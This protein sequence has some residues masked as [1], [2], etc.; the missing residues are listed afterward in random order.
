M[1]NFLSAEKLE[2]LREAFD[3]GMSIRDAM[4]YSGAAKGTVSHWF[5]EWGWSLEIRKQHDFKRWN[6]VRDGSRAPK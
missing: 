3:L 6:E 5:H 1:A 4:K 2:R